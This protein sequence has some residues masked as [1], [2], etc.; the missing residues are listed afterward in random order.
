VPEANRTDPEVI[1][2]FGDLLL[3]VKLAIPLQRGSPPV[4]RSG[5]A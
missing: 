2:S 5:F 3:G 1:K 4:A